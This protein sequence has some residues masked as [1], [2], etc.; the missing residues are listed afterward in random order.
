M[1]KDEG[2]DGKVGLIPKSE[3]YDEVWYKIKK[4]NK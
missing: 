4:K 3:K 2:Q 1:K